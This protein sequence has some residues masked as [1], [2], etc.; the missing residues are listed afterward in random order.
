MD[1]GGFGIRIDWWI[2]CLTASCEY[3]I[4]MLISG[5]LI[6]RFR[7]VI[8]LSLLD[9]GFEIE[10][11]WKGR[12]V[13]TRLEISVI[14]S[15]LTV[16]LNSRISIVVVSLIFASSMSSVGIVGFFF[17]GSSHGFVIT[18]RGWVW[19]S[20]TIASF[21][22]LLHFSFDI[23]E[24]RVN[25]CGQ[26]LHLF[27]ELGVFAT[28]RESN[29]FP[30][31]FGFDVFRPIEFQENSIF[32]HSVFEQSVCLV[33][34]IIEK[35]S[36]GVKDS[37]C[38]LVKSMVEDLDDDMG[39]DVDISALTIEQ[40][41]ALIQDNSRPGIVKPKIGDDV[42]FKI[43][44]NFMRE[45]RRKFFAGTDDEDAHEYVRRV[46]EIVDLFHF[47]GVTHDVVMLRVFPITLKGRALRWKKGF[48]QE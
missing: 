12:V 21:S 25:F 27:Y 26:C 30:K 39:D 28:F 13:F 15:W 36:S 47:P 33:R 48:Q 42:E 35:N 11:L 46:L 6:G 17:F 14:V 2:I 7:L 40:Y 44:R 19:S 4:H 10:E 31:G 22:Y 16:T 5:K 23:F 29:S 37:L 3:G 20:T 34:G 8:L 45:L 24:L 9:F 18:F 32:E 43:N 1:D 41:L 38:G